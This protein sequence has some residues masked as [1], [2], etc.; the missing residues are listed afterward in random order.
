MVFQPE[1]APSDRAEF[2]AWYKQLTTWTEDHDYND[3]Q[4]TTPALQAWYREMIKTFPALNGPDAAAIDD[5]AS[6]S[7]YV[8]DYCCASNAVYVGFRWSVQKEAYRLVLACA[9]KH[10]VGFFDVSATDGAVW[11]PTADGYAIVHGGGPGDQEV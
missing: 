10:Q 6:D 7:A 2:L 4:H 11:Q 8:T 1:A 9:T 5:P 3:P